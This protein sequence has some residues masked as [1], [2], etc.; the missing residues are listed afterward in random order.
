MNKTIVIAKK[1]FADYFY[2]PIGYVF[3]GIMLLLAGWVFLGDVFVAGNSDIKPLLQTLSYLFSVFV[4]AITMGAI[5][6]EKKSGT[7]EVL[8]SSPV[9]IANIYWGKLLAGIGFL[10]VSL[11]MT[12]PTLFSLLWLGQMDLG[13]VLSG[14]IGLLLLGT[15]Y[16]SIGLFVSGLTKHSAGAF[17]ITTVILVLNSLMS[18]EMV[19]SKL[20][21]FLVNIFSQLSLPD[22]MNG[23][24]NGE[25]G[26]QTV[27]YLLSV[28][29]VV[30]ILAIRSNE[31]SN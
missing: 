31:K 14:Y 11:L 6:D 5:A 7:W 17:I 2:S 4:P 8:T 16:L 15:T 10:M 19:L 27:L 13:V 9:T 21:H 18:Q 1:E 24:Y 3:L 26:L 20:P 23:F 28:S 25:I 29:C 22:K 12:L 30:T